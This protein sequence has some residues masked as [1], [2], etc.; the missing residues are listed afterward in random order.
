MSHKL[1]IFNLFIEPVQIPLWVA[2]GNIIF[3][4]SPNSHI[5]M[6]GPGLVYYVVLMSFL[7]ASLISGTGCAPFR[8]YIEEQISFSEEPCIDISYPCSVSSISFIL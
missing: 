8:A 6:I 7:I 1:L 3:P 2:P 5:I 4:P